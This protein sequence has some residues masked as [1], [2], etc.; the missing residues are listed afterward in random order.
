MDLS[1]RDIE[2]FREKLIPDAEDV[3][4]NVVGLIRDKVPINKVYDREEI[5]RWVKNNESPDD[6]FESSD[7]KDWA[8]C[9]DYILKED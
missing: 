8:E 1:Y 4:S 7:L 9:N 5:I 2:L 6:V 3:F